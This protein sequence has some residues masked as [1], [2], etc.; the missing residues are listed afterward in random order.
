MGSHANLEADANQVPKSSSL[1]YTN[2]HLQFGRFAPQSPAVV[3]LKALS[4]PVPHFPLYENV[5]YLLGLPILGYSL[6]I[7]KEHVNLTDERLENLDYRQAR[8]LLCNRPVTP[9][10]QE[11][12]GV[13]TTIS[14]IKVEHHG[15]KS[16]MREQMKAQG[17]ELKAYAGLR[18]IQMS[19]LQISLPVPDLATPSTSEPL[20]LEDYL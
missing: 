5:A 8:M 13:K 18:A 14:N 1:A 11:H 4:V 19:S 15:I 6:D 7:G 10:R 9:W 2:S 12:R 3:F 16:T 20:H 17:E